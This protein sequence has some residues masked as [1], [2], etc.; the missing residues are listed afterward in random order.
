V[1]PPATGSVVGGVVGG[2]V[3][4]GVEVVVGGVEVVV[5]GAKPVVSGPL[6]VQAPA[7]S[8]ITPT[9]SQYRRTRN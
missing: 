4:D 8:A 7:T 9:R 6:L 2:D 1:G 5:G 3:V